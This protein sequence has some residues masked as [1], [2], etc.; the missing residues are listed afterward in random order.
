[1]ILFGRL[2]CG[3]MCPEGSL[4]EFASR[5]GRGRSTPRWMRWK[6]WP[7]TAFVLTTVYGQMVSVYQY[8]KP[9]AL[10]LGGSTL[11][12]IADRLSL[13]PREARVVPLSLPRQRRLRA[14]F[15]ARAGAFFDRPRRLGGRVRHGGTPPS[16]QLRAARAPEARSTAH[17]LATCAAAAPAFRDAIEL[18]SRPLGSEIVKTSGTTANGWESAL[19]IIG[20]MG[21]AVG[22]FQWSVSPWFVAVK[23]AIALWLVDHDIMWPLSM[24]LPWWILT[25]Y[26]ERN[27]VLTVLDGAI[28]LFYIAAAAVVDELRPRICLWRSPTGSSA[29]EL[30]PLPS[31][32]PVLLPLAACGVILGLSSQTVTLL[33]A[34]GFDLNWVSDARIAALAVATAGTM[35]LFWGIAG[36]YGKKSTRL[37]AT[38]VMLPAPAIAVFAWVLQFWIW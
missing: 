28:L 37:S 7:F 30:A 32:R 14:S 9:A 8:P 15:E 10:I 12:A 4:S 25:D 5:H 1:M 29:V 6:G 34:D 27:D 16:G 24:R 17:R 3:V 20:L 31:S 38:A 36:Q 21:V 19:I 35:A 22:A 2:W 26:A 18:K 33:H 13:R 11:G 23:Q